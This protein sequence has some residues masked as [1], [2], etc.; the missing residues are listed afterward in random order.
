LYKKIYFRAY[1]GA[2]PADYYRNLQK[3]ID[4]NPTLNLNINTIYESWALQGGYP[5]LHV[6][7]Q[8]TEDKVALLLSQEQ[9][10]SKDTETK[11][12]ALWWIPYNV[13][14]NKN[15]NFDSTNF[16]GWLSQRETTITIDASVTADDWIVLNKQQ[17]GYYRIN[18]EIRMWKLIGEQL[19]TNAAVIHPN[20]RGQLIDDAFNLA[21]SK[22]LEYSVVL[23]LIEFLKDEIDYVPWAAANTGLRYMK[24]M[25]IA[26][27]HYKEF[28]VKFTLYLNFLN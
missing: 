1:Q 23:E 5:V 22:H 6:T 15:P 25:L 7:R 20:N 19:K 3:A 16:D 14:T 2:I 28:Q 11:T 10:W 12:N 27:E 9:Y 4:E 8:I 18:Y 17:T 26:S 13:A 24:Q 21:R